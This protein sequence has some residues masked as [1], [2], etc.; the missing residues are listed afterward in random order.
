MWQT[1]NND[2]LNVNN[3]QVY[4]YCWYPKQKH[5]SGSFQFQ[6]FTRRQKVV[7]KLVKKKKLS[8]QRVNVIQL[9]I[10]WSNFPNQ[11]LPYIAYQCALKEMKLEK[12]KKKDLFLRVWWKLNIRVVNHSNNYIFKYHANKSLMKNV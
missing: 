2:K 11:V 10:D 3:L 12:A 4:D 8:Y 9:S 1:T 5:A 6:W 7:S